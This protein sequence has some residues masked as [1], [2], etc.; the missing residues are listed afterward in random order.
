MTS[1]NTCFMLARAHT[2]TPAGTHTYTQY[3]LQKLV[4]IT[5]KSILF[6]SACN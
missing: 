2:H 1:Q 3:F 4:C 5:L 6:I